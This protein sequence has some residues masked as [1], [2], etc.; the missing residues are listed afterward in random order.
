[1]LFKGSIAVDCESHM[2]HTNPLCGQN[3]EFECVKADNIITTGLQK[4][5]I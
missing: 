2:K 5:K 1:M 3:A 4:V